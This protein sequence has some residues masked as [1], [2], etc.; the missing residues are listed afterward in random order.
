M[1]KHHE[2]VDQVQGTLEIYK[3]MQ[4]LTLEFQE[5]NAEL[6]AL[7]RS[8]AKARKLQSGLVDGIKA[9]MT[10]CQEAYQLAATCKVPLP[11]AH[12]DD[13]RGLDNNRNQLFKFPTFQTFRAKGDPEA[14]CAAMEPLLYS[15]GYGPPHFVRALVFYS[16]K[17]VRKWAYPN[18]L[19]AGLPWD[20][21]KKLFV[22]KYSAFGTSESKADRFE[23]L[24]QNYLSVAEFAD[25]FTGLADDLDYKLN[26]DDVIRAFLRKLRQDLRTKMKLLRLSLP[27]EDRNNFDRILALTVAQEEALQGEGDTRR[28]QPRD[29][30]D[31]KTVRRQENVQQSRYGGSGYSQARSSARQNSAPSSQKFE[32]RNPEAVCFAC[33]VKG[34]Y[35]ADPVSKVEG[36]AC[37]G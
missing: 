8:D 13:E 25:V 15:V 10:R 31:W 5:A 19:Q 2:A 6:M 27:R 9:D 36:Q 22:A 29:K 16:S 11:K 30:G 7:D 17:S 18:L 23:D 37:S 26:S 3:Q 24:Q 28:Q 34:H 14:F 21:A 12:L 33:G 1:E 32:K 35:R 4:K 20:E